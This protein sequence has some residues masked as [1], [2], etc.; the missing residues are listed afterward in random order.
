MVLRADSSVA[1]AKF[2]L[3]AIVIQISHFFPKSA[4]VAFIELLLILREYCGV[5]ISWKKLIFLWIL[6]PIDSP[7][8]LE[9]VLYEITFISKF[10]RLELTTSVHLGPKN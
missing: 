4:I 6:A 8:T 10:I 3:M 9:S 2:I 5:Q 1:S 7:V